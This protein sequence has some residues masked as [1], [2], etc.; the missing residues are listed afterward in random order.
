M[1]S[2]STGGITGWSGG[3]LLV[4]G[5]A[6]FAVLSLLDA[7]ASGIAAIATAAA[8]SSRLFVYSAALSLH[9]RH[10]PRWFRWAAS[11][12]LVDQVFAMADERLAR[13]DD[14]TRFRHWYLAIAAMLWVMWATAIAAGMVVGPVVP[15][16][17]RIELAAI[18]LIV[19]ILRPALT[20]RTGIVA[21]AVAG[22]VALLG[23]AMP[24]R[25][26][27]LVGALV[28][29]AAATAIERRHGVDTESVEDTDDL[30]ERSKP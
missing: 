30:S 12:L 16:G 26:G 22:S 20:S 2:L 6:H 15:A 9:F 3:P 17:W 24:H 5:A 19:A 14:P 29:M 7:G 8:I 25:T 1:N 10:Q 23:A 11:Y 4:S 27:L 13:D 21:A 18:L 28:G